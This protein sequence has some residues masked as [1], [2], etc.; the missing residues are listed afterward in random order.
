[1]W[2]RLLIFAI[3]CDTNRSSL[4]Q[5]DMVNHAM[6]AFSAGDASLNA[7][8]IHSHAFTELTHSHAAKAM[9]MLRNKMNKAWPLLNDATIVMTAFHLFLY[10]VSL[11]IDTSFS[12]CIREFPTDG[13]YAW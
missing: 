11:Q 8:A 5:D 10:A 3:A 6:L 9:T 2:H 13:I 12:V 4:L 7:R 1:M